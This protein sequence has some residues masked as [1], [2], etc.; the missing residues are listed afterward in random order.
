[1]DET[2]LKEGSDE[3]S[4]LLVPN[5]DNTQQANILFKDTTDSPPK[6]TNQSIKTDQVKQETDQSQQQETN[7]AK[8]KNAGQRHPN[9]RI[10]EILRG[11]VMSHVL[12][13][14]GQISVTRHLLIITQHFTHFDCMCSVGIMDNV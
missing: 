14:H 9:R 5:I 3:V 10:Y 8:P 12:Y 11:Y 2:L 1:M 4:H 7:Q 6:Q 13:S